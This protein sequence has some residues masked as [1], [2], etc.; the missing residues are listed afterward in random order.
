MLFNSPH[1]P[2]LLLLLFIKIATSPPLSKVS[3]TLGQP[4]SEIG[5]IVQ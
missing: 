2:L 5:D 3:V 1:P 4:L